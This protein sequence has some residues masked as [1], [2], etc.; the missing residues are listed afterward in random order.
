MGRATAP[1]QIK[2]LGKKVV[3]L[4][5]DV[6]TTRHKEAWALADGI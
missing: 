5:S 1:Q 4:L 2:Q 3:A 6:P